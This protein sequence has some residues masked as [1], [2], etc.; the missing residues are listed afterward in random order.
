MSKNGPKGT[1][2]VAIPVPEFNNRPPSAFFDQAREKFKEIGVILE[3][4]WYVRT[5][6]GET[7][8]ANGQLVGQS[9]LFYARINEY[10]PRPNPERGD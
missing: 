9:M 7:L 2:W 8:M 5:T 1:H 6:E 10:V 4:P 3:G